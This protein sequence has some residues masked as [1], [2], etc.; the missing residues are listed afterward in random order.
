MTQHQHKVGVHGA[1]GQIG[2]QSGELFLALS[3]N[4]LLGEPLVAIDFV[5]RSQTVGLDSSGE[6]AVGGVMVGVQAGLGVW[7]CTP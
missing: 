5:E 7:I 1:V 3:G 6:C 4:S 2:V